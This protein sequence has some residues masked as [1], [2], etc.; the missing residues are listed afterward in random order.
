MQ[1]SFKSKTKSLKPTQKKKK[2]NVERTTGNQ[3]FFWEEGHSDL[4]ECF[5]ARDAIVNLNI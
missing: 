4:M 1:G 5:G 3:I 2:K